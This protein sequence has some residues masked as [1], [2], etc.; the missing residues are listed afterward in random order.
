MA[1]NWGECFEMVD[2]KVKHPVVLKMINQNR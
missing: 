1:I 2:L